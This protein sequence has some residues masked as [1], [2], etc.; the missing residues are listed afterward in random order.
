MKRTHY[1]QMPEL[2]VI[3]WNLQRASCVER[4]V[5]LMEVFAGALKSRDLTTRHQI[6][7][8]GSYG[9]LFSSKVT[10]YRMFGG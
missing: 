10:G 1:I 5:Q 8:Y 7:S 2:R 9:V 3:F 6:I 4:R